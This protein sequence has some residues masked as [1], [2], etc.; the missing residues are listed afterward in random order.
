MNHSNP[1][2]S[3]Q[4]ATTSERAASV[5]RRGNPQDLADRLDPEGVAMLIDEGLQ[6]LKRR[7]SFAWVKN[8]LA[9][10]RISSVRR[11]SLAS[12]SK[13]LMRSRSAVRTPSRFPRSSLS[14]LTQ[15]NSVCG[16]AANHRRN[17][18]DCRPLRRVLATLLAYQA[19]CALLDFPEKTCLASC[20]W[21]HSL[22]SWSLH[23]TR[24]GSPIRGRAIMVFSRMRI[25]VWGFIK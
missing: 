20:S 2:T 4:A 10:S 13:A 15:S 1:A 25:I 24:G 19:Y 6:D 18:F 14:R 17:R 22:K 5:A 7:S 11:S 9:S 3:A 21:L 12:R 8:A 23:K 16:R